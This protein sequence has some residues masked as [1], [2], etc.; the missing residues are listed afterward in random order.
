MS[1]IKWIPHPAPQRSSPW[2]W[3]PWALAVAMGVVVAVNMGMVY[4]ALHSFPGKAGDNEF[5]LSN[6][7]D[8][9]LEQVQRE[10][11]LGWTVQAQPD[12]AGRP[13]VTLTDRN[14]APLS[15]AR[16]AGT[17]ERPLGTA[18]ARRLAFH[19]SVAGHYVADTALPLAGQ[20][21]LLLSAS[22]QGHDIATTR[23]IVVR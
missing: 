23:R 13:V 2:R 18:E 10:A 7:Y 17:A 8:R 1:Y 14:G 6:R 9:V 21:D 20:W 3:F 12:A 11:A 19:E 5:E 16:L 4:A 15:G 22:A